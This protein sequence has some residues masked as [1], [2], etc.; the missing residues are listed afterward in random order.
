MTNYTSTLSSLSLKYKELIANKTSI[1]DQD[2]EQCLNIINIVFEHLSKTYTKFGII[3]Y[4]SSYRFRRR[5]L[6]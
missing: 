2:Q 1:H 6:F 5:N 3:C 4:S